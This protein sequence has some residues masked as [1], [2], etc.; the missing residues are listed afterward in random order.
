VVPLPTTGPPMPP[1]T[2][3]TVSRRCHRRACDPE[4]RHLLAALEAMLTYVEQGQATP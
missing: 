3:R 2:R 1:R 4:N